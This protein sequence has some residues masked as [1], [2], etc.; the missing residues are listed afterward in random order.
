MAFAL[1]IWHDPAMTS[2]NPM[3][4]GFFILVAIAIG[5][6]W[7]LMAG[8]ATLGVIGGTAVGIAVALIVWLVDRVRR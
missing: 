1:V 4:G 6:V 3:A 7:G 2:R 8:Q 5:L